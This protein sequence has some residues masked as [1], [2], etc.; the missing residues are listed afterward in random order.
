M[1][2]HV[3]EVTENSFE[4]DV[5]QSDLPVLVDFWAAWCGPCRML[6]PV[7]EAA[8][9]DELVGRDAPYSAIRAAE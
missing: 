3:I 5:L 7:V 4:K 9:S 6:A 1:S 8:T 2:E